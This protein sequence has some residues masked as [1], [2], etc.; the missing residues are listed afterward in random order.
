MRRGEALNSAALLI[1]QDRRVLARDAI[2]EIADK[3]FYLIRMVDISTKQNEA[4][5]ALR[6]KKFSFF[7]ARGR[8]RAAADESFTPRHETSPEM[9]SPLRSTFAFT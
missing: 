7:A 9:R 8:S 6:S 1:D 3:L 5:G 4:P 2:S